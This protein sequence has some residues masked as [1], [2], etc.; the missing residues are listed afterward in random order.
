MLPSPSILSPVLRGA[1][2]AA[3]HSMPEGEQGRQTVDL[4]EGLST[5]DPLRWDEASLNSVSEKSRLLCL[6]LIPSGTARA[7][8]SNNEATLVFLILHEVHK[9]LGEVVA[10]FQE[11]AHLILHLG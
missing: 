7:E 10:K 5:S 8:W 6:P 2:L 9:D 11:G 4:P 1:A 3:T